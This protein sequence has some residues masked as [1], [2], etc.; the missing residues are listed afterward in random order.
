MEL[1]V[2]KPLPAYFDKVCDAL[3]VTDRSRVVM[4]GDSLS[5]DILGGNNAGIDTIWYNPKG[6]SLT[7]KA[8][9]TYT[10]YNYDEILSL[11]T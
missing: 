8:C 1:G 9:P 3:N 5:S 2:Q 4:I 6:A 11:L 10:V 7:G